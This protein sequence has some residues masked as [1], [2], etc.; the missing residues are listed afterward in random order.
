MHER[1]AMLAER[2]DAFVALPGGYGTMDE[3]IEILTWAQ[4]K[5]H[6]KPCVLVNVA[7]F[8]DGLL[9]FLDTCVEQGFILAENRRLVQVV[10]DP[11]E[12]LAIVE[13]TWRERAEVPAHDARLDAVVR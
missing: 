13:S 10:R 3:F 6:A 4:L 12:A 2:A 1:K 9:A 7:G 11:E 5:I 8:Y